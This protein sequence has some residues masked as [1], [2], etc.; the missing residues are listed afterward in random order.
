MHGISKAEL[1]LT[2]DGNIHFPDESDMSSCPLFITIAGKPGN[3]A[4]QPKKER[5]PKIVDVTLQIKGIEKKAN[6]NFLIHNTPMHEVVG[7]EEKRD[8][9]DDIALRRTLM[10][11]N[12]QV[13]NILIVTVT[14][15]ETRAI[16]EI[17]LPKEKEWPQLGTG[18]GDNTYYDLGV[19]QNGVPVCM[20][21]SEPSSATPG[22]A[23]STISK[24]IKELRPQAVIM[25]GIAFGLQQN[26][27]QLGDILI[28]KQIQ[29][30]EFQ[31]VDIKRGRRIARGDRSTSSERLLDRF[32]NGDNQWQEK[33]KTHFGV[34]LS[35]E[36]LVNDPD[37]RNSLLWEEPEAL[38][39]EMEG[40][41]L[42]V[43]ARD[44]KADWILV[45]AISDWGDGSK[46]D[47][48]QLLAAHNAARFVLHVLQV[49]RWGRPSIHPKHKSAYIST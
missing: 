2:T 47:D 46:N 45:K 24:A 7:L 36:K 37:F 41:G 40:A 12:K 31:K 5:Q 27:Q 4:E 43:A 30:Y 21:Q 11:N 18:D 32:R 20:V 1:I 38:G 28:A 3:V 9:G 34:V 6:H 13:D 29:C 25:C 14:K 42:Y 35:G 17:F 44:T 48:V 26:T 23:M 33:A 16:H 39:G 8:G 49:G 19:L 10:D 15:T 22:G